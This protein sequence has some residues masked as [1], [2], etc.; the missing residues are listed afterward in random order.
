MKKKKKKNFLGNPL[1]NPYKLRGG[2]TQHALAAAG[3]RDDDAVF[4][5]PLPGGQVGAV[6]PE[7]DGLVVSDAHLLTQVRSGVAPPFIVTPQ[8]GIV[9]AVAAVHVPG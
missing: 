4:D 7:G 2:R 9:R 5:D 6:S 1:G 8:R 3:V